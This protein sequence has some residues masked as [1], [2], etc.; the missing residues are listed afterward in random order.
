MCLKPNIVM[1]IIGLLTSTP[2]F[3]LPQDNKE[4][5]III[6]DSS[7]YNYKTGIKIFV[8]HVKVDQGA[9]HLIADKLITKENKKHKMEE[10]I[11]YGAVEPAHYWTVPKP[12]DLDMHANAKI[13]KFYPHTSNVVLEQNARVTQGKNSFQGELIL[14]NINEQTVT[15][16]PSKNA[17]AVLVYNPDK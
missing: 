1:C 15:V 9:T 10:A 7:S 6:S 8:G 4:K 2:L 3:A 11:A 17:R 5:L 14:Y 16:P 13:I 12:G